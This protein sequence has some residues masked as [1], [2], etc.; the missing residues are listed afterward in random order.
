MR[1]RKGL[2]KRKIAHPQNGLCLNEEMA[3]RRPTVLGDR[4]EKI[5]SEQFDGN[6]S[7]LARAIGVSPST[8]GRWI[9]DGMVP[10]SA[11]MEQICRALRIPISELLEDSS[12]QQ[13]RSK[14]SKPDDIACAAQASAVDWLIE[15]G[16]NADVVS[17]AATI[18]A[19][20][21]EGA[22]DRPRIWWV[23]QINKLIHELG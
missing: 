14:S 22:A 21:V 4:L 6:R 7:E 16:E 13:Q 10:G 15:Q 1:T 20:R 12:G 17:S 23:A 9:E 11:R 5:E 3:K 2:R 19:I 18:I 8:V